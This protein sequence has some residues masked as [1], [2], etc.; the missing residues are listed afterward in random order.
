MNNGFFGSGFVQNQNQTKYNPNLLNN[1]LFQN[2]LSKD[3]ESSKNIYAT[4]REKRPN[5]NDHEKKSKK[6]FTDYNCDLKCSCFRTQCD[7]KYCEC[8]NN[9]RYCINCNCTN[10]SNK[11][12][13]N[14]TTDVRPNLNNENINKEKK[15]YCTCSKSGCKLKYC[16]CYK[17]NLECSNL[18]RCTKCENTKIPKEKNSFILKICYANSIYVIDNILKEDLKRTHFKKCFLNKKRKKPDYNREKGDNEE[19][20]TKNKEDEN[21]TGKL[22]D[23][24]G[25]MIF[26]HIKLS[27]IKKHF[28]KNY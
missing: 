10:C 22:F 2:L 14:S 27:E 11:P 18:C 17:N 25:N 16:E 12:P 8:F 26:T 6:F 7:K 20:E 1:F 9:R 13:K 24:N 15:L 19:N 21:T 23:K 28:H 3:E 5:K 4:K